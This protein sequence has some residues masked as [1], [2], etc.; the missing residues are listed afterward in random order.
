MCLGRLQQ[1]CQQPESNQAM[2]DRIVNYDL[3][4]AALISALLR[5]AKH[6]TSLD[7]G[8]IGGDYRLRKTCLTPLHLFVRR[9]S[10]EYVGLDMNLDGL[11]RMHGTKSHLV[12]ATAHCLPFK[13]ESFDYVVACNLLEHLD[14]PG[15]F[16]DECA[17]R[18]TGLGS[19]RP[20]E[21]NI[22]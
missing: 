11:R 19:R 14:L 17:R 10:T 22:R 8:S 2:C 6:A 21:R 16:L 1:L 15:L 5:S 20:I 12:L 7:V 13:S 9:Y 4:R 18:S 3:A